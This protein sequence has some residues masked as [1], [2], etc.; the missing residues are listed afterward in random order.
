MKLFKF[1][2]YLNEGEKSKL[3][4]NNITKEMIQNEVMSIIKDNQFYECEESW[5]IDL[6]N[7]EIQ[8]SISDIIEN[9]VYTEI[10]VD[11]DVIL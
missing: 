7:L 4:D 9:G 10:K 2:Y 3:W 8:F 1:K 6:A 11:I 5:V